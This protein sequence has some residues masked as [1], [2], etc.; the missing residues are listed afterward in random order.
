MPIDYYVSKLT[1][2]AEWKT[3]VL[4]IWNDLLQEF[5]DIKAIVS[6]HNRLWS[7]VAAAGEHS[8]HFVL[9]LSKL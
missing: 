6:F 2:I 5:I 8:G 7:C 9:I 4:I 3:V 1:N